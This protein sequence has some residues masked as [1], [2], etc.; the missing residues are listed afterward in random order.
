MVRLSQGPQVWI[1]GVHGRA[2]D[3]ENSERMAG[4][5]AQAEMEPLLLLQGLSG[6]LQGGWALLFRLLAHSLP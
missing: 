6:S 3:R 1:S 5:K 2:G 4:I